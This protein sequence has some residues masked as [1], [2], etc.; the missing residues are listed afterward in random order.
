MQKITVVN[1]QALILKPETK[2]NFGKLS[3]WAWLW[4]VKELALVVRAV[5]LHEA[6]VLGLESCKWQMFCHACLEHHSTKP[7]A[8]VSDYFNVGTLQILFELGCDRPILR[9]KA[10]LV[11]FGN[12]LIT[13]SGCYGSHLITRSG[14]YDSH[15][16]TRSEII[17]NKQTKN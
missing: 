11:W 12:H 5:W 10:N 9:L 3:I 16:I 1:W 8:G 13:R 4:R 15:L 17:I 2:I 7:G 6:R 14:C